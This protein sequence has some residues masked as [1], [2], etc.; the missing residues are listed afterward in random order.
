LKNSIKK[1]FAVIF[2]VFFSFSNLFVFSVL[3][4]SSISISI[5]TTSNSVAKGGT[6]TISLKAIVSADNAVANIDGL[7]LSY[8]KENYE[9]ADTFSRTGFKIT[10]TNGKVNIYYNQLKSPDFDILN[11][12]FEIPITFKVK[13][14]A[15]VGAS[16]AFSIS[17]LNLYKL[18]NG[19]FE[20]LNVTTNPSS[21][22]V[23]IANL[24]SNNSMLKSLSLKEASLVPIFSRTNFEYNASVSTSFTKVNVE[25]ITDDENA[26]VKVVGNTDLTK[27]INTVMIVVT[28]QDGSS[29]TYKINVKKAQTVAG[30]NENSNTENAGEIEVLQLKI[31]DL[32]LRNLIV[33]LIFSFILLA[34]T[35]YVLVDKFGHKW[36][37]TEKVQEKKRLKIDKE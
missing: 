18:A 10:D 23:S 6:F 17:N 1:V 30:E 27:E 32:E 26:T 13:S 20:K 16:S 29:S 5:A 31:K 34:L 22:V 33:I 8:D 37:K 24:K 7:I 15:Q 25:Y 28:A 19:K 36:F 35:S 11:R 21:V 9:V 2:L 3:S 4:A 12:S 14:T